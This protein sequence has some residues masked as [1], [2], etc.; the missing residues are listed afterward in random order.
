[1]SAVHVS[2][3]WLQEER[4]SWLGIIRGLKTQL[5]GAGEQIAELQ[6]TLRCKEEELAERT[7]EL[8]YAEKTLERVQGW[9]EELRKGK[10]N[11]N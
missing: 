11:G 3:E 2:L 5:V 9:M 6:D 1:M 10:T 7:E 8:R 4:E